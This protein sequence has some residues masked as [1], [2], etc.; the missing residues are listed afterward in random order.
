MER[1]PALTN[2]FRSRHI[3]VPLNPARSNRHGSDPDEMESPE[4]A[5]SGAESGND[6]ADHNGS[7]VLHGLKRKRPV[8]VSYVCLSSVS[9]F[10]H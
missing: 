10:R 9:A 8:T 2:S 4:D 5:W 3:P 6:L 1:P 7:Q